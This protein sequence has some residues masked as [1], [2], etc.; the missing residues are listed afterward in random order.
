M[1]KVKAVAQP[2]GALV[3][4]FQLLPELL[5][6]VEFRENHGYLVVKLR[7]VTIRNRCNDGGAHEYIAL[8]GWSTRH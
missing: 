5:M 2:S 6:L 8:A 4:A 1:N 3:T 7:V